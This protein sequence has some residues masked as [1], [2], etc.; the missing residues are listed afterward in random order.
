MNQQAKEYLEK[1][2]GNRVNFDEM[3]RR[4]YSHD[5]AAIPSLI[6]PL[7]GKTIPRCRS[8]AGRR[9]R[10]CCSRQLGQGK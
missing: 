9:R 7:I 6:Q 1:Q 8:P 2:F 5:I 3:E 10:A 4:L